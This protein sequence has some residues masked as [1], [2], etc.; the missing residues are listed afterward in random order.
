MTERETPLAS[1]YPGSVMEQHHFRYTST[2]LQDPELNIFN[3]LSPEMYR[4][5]MLLMR[6][7]ILATDLANLR[8]NKKRL[9]SLL[10]PR[11]FDWSNQQHRL[12]IMLIIMNCCDL[13]AG[14]QTVA[15]NRAN[16]FA[17]MEE[18]WQQGDEDRLLG[19]P[20]DLMYDRE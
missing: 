9:E 11:I 1:L 8:K 17:V 3:R 19:K 20:V 13:S 12:R 10:E 5:V 6:S 18:F 14:Y 4:T 2:L 7:C 16:A 15:G